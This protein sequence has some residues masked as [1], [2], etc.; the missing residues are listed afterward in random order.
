MGLGERKG[1]NPG[2][3]IIYTVTAPENPIIA[4]AVGKHAD[5]G[6]HRQEDVE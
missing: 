3:H 6:S 2:F 1:G 5:R 4:V